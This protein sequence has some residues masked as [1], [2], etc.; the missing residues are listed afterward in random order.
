MLARMGSGA[1]RFPGLEPGAQSPLRGWRI[2][3]RAKPA[4]L[5][6]PFVS[7]IL[8]P[9]PSP[10]TGEGV[11]HPVQTRNQKLLLLS[12]QSLEEADD[13]LDPAIK[14][15]DVELLVGSV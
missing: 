12:S 8:N 11:G 3:R 4:R 1:E 2:P 13:G 7:G 9:H 15:G 5:G 10:E 6:H 14:I